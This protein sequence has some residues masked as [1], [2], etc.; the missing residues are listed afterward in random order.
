MT[1]VFFSWAPQSSQQ[2]D[3]YFK[4][5]FAVI[6]ALKSFHFPVCLSFFC[7]KFITFISFLTIILKCSVNSPFLN[8]SSGF[9]K[10]FDEDFLMNLLTPNFEFLITNF[11]SCGKNFTFIMS[12]NFHIWW[13]CWA[14]Y[15]LRSY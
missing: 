14:Y 6:F 1:A 8:V 12:Q 3:L 9:I 4:L 7:V 2:V 11:I 5:F 10:S 13:C 15:C